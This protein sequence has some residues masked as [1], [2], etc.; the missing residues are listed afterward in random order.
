M[1][2]LS[3]TD[4]Q[5]LGEYLAGTANT[6]DD[7]IRVLELEVEDESVL[8]A[9]LLD[10]EVQ[11]CNNCGWWHEVC[12]MEY[13]ASEEEAFCDQFIEALGLEP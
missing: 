8:E 2:Q 11:H 10:V 3:E 13:V 6:I 1:A 9:E 5:R 7:G 12:E 4:L